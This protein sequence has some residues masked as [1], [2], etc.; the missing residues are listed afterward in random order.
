MWCV[1]QSVHSSNPTIIPHR[2]VQH[3]R[4]KERTDRRRLSNRTE[5]ENRME[6]LP[7]ANRKKHPQFTLH[8]IPIQPVIH[9]QPSTR[10][11]RTEF[12]FYRVH[13]YITNQQQLNFVVVVVVEEDKT[14][15]ECKLN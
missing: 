9:S 11:Y 6:C 5:N 14:G 7:A 12:P 10:L 4:Q 8:S 1:S 13:F 2:I 3:D 15:I